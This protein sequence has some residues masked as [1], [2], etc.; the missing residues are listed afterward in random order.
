MTK[1]CVC[2]KQAVGVIS[3]LFGHKY[4]CREHATAAEKEGLVVDYENWRL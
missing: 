2:G 3:T 4:V 1:E